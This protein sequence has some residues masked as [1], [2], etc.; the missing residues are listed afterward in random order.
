MEHQE[1]PL[2]IEHVTLGEHALRHNAYAKALHYKELQFFADSSPATIEALI[3]INTR[4]QQHDAAWGT[5]VTAREQYDIQEH[6]EWYEKLGRWQEALLAYDKKAR[7]YA[8]SMETEIGRMKCLHALGEWDQ[9]AVQVERCWGDA[10]P[11]HRT[12]ISPMA[13]AAAWS[14]ADWDSMEGYIGTMKS[15]SSD[16]HF[17]KAIM[18]VHQNNFP[19]A[20][21]HIAKTRDLLYPE[22]TSFVGDGYGRAYK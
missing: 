21:F 7:E 2:P 13:A 22:L 18:A 20:L 16:R 4:L 12:E 17:Y 9:L 19:R 11:Q 1:K 6:E 15:D 3:S 14:L 10:N 8:P 5:L